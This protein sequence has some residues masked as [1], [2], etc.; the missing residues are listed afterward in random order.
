MGCASGRELQVVNDTNRP[1]APPDP[2]P[3]YSDL[4]IPSNAP[5]PNINDNRNWGANFDPPSNNNAYGSDAAGGSLNRRRSSKNNDNS[6]ASIS[7]K[8]ATPISKTQDNKFDDPVS[9]N[10]ADEQAAQSINRSNV[11]IR[12]KPATPINN[13]E[14]NRSRPV[15]SKK[16]DGQ[17]A[18]SMNRSNASIRS[19]SSADRKKRSFGANPR[20]ITNV[21]KSS[22]AITTFTVLWSDL[23]PVPEISLQ[24]ASELQPSTPAECWDAVR[25]TSVKY[26]E[27]IKPAVKRRGWKTIR[28]FVSSTFKDFHAEREVLVKQVSS[29][30][31]R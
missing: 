8:P 28:L 30:F 7:P 23:P 15:S 11:S 17:T 29:S 13:A 6:T 25:A 19:S 4:P 24:K 21:T 5:K 14:N 22:G 27:D 9:S 3:K 20:K 26:Q 31:G 16:S 1:A 18:Q 12:S 2:P 10:K